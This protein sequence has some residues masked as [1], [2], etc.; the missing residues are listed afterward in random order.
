[1]MYEDIVKRLRYENLTVLQ[2][3]DLMD[4]AA[5]AI[6]K[7]DAKY[8]MALNDIVQQSKES[9]GNK[10]RKWI[11]VTERLPEYMENVLVTD[12][13]F[14]G[15]GWRD[16]YDCYDTKPR[17]YWIA[18]STNVNESNITHWMPLPEPPKDGE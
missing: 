12:G 18:P 1:M 13:V 16:W 5:D 2:M 6:E 17:E 10:F 11:P 3:I 4:E 14:S 15:M 8:Q 7:L 9:E